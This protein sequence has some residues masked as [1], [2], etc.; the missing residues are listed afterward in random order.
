MKKLKKINLGLVLTIVTVL[1][2]TGYSINLELQRKNFKDEIR[3]S[4]EEYISLIDKYI[5][6]P[7]DAQKNEENAKD[8][9]LDN[10]KSDMEKDLKDVMVSEKAAD[11]QK[12]ILTDIAERD[13][14][15]TSTFTTNYERKISKVKSYEFD[16][17]QVTVIFESKVTVKQK[18]LDVNIET[19]EKQ[20]KVKENTYDTKGD[21]ITLEMKDG[22]WKVV[23]SNFDYSFNDYTN[24]M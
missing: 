5:V 3:K 9:N 13:L 21:T 23:H 14:L 7:E 22:K 10:Y 19:G 24:V 4:C 16:G 15:N 2:V 12:T 8:V 6:L 18:Y 17:N 1:A 11:I 20:E